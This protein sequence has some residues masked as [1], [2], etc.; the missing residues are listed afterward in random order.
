M[1]ELGFKDFV[2]KLGIPT[3]LGIAQTALGIGQM[4]KGSKM[5]KEA[6]QRFQNYRVPPTIRAML[7]LAH[8]MS[9]QRELPGADVLRSGVKGQMAQ[10]VE[11]ASRA[12]ESGTDV[13][14]AVTDM[15]R[16]YGNWEQGMAV[17]GAEMQRQAKM[18]EFNVMRDIGLHEAE[19]WKY[20][21]LYPYMQQM[22]AAAQMSGAGGANLQSALS[23]GMNIGNTWG[24]MNQQQDMFDQ[25]LKWKLGDAQTQANRGAMNNIANTAPQID[26]RLQVPY[27]RQPPINILAATGGYDPQMGQTGD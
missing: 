4:I 15:F 19:A 7:G 11:K 18:N 2:N 23:T 25:W 6:E 27:T 21:E 8:G 17:K 22:N 14:G 24:D 20:N 10:G 26:P 12:A 9:S 1:A 13:L 5:R 3:G 16:S